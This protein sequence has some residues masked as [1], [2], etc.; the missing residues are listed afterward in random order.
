MLIFNRGGG[1]G[2]VQWRAMGALVGG[3][4]ALN[5]DEK[6]QAL[7]DERSSIEFL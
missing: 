1:G 4:R 2:G 7:F 3:G 6:T 5:M